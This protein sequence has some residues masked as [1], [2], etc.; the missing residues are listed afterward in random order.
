MRINT[1]IN[2]E[3]CSQHIWERMKKDTRSFKEDAKCKYMYNAK[4]NVMYIKHFCFL[5]GFLSDQ[6]I[7]RRQRQRQNTGGNIKKTGHLGQ[8]IICKGQK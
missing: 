8:E 2:T 7:E 4:L 3:S 5:S 1:V 6:L